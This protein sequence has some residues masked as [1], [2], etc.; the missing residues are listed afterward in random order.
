MCSDA[1]R[2]GTAVVKPLV[3][4]ALFA[5][6]IGRVKIKDFNIWMLNLGHNL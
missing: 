4:A 6:E 1:G 3:G 2:W 5:A